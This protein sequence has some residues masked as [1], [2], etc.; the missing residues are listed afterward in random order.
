MGLDEEELRM[1]L[2]H[3]RNTITIFILRNTD[4]CT[5]YYGNNSFNYDGCEKN[6]AKTANTTQAK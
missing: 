5:N 2:R 4:K 1:S 6:D 3:E